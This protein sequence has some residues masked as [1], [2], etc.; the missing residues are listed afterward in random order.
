MLVSKFS[1]PWQTA[2][3]WMRLDETYGHESKKRRIC[4]NGRSRTPTPLWSIPVCHYEMYLR[5]T[6]TVKKVTNCRSEPA[7]QNAEKEILM[8]MCCSS[9]IGVGLS[10]ASCECTQRPRR[11]PLQKGSRNLQQNASFEAA[12]LAEAP[13]A[14]CRSLWPGAAPLRPGAEVGSAALSGD[15]IGYAGFSSVRSSAI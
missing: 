6:R 9:R 10:E 13:P 2:N 11:S 7:C 4:H 12:P 15:Q 14:M 5:L 8:V 1:S 3:G